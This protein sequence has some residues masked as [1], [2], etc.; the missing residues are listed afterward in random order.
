MI[1]EGEVNA[2]YFMDVTATQWDKETSIYVVG[3]D[4]SRLPGINV[5]T[6]RHQVGFYTAPQMTNENYI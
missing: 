5:W 6:D 1:A 3:N 2:D 4:G